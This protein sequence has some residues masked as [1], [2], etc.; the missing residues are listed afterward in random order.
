MSIC[1]VVGGNGGWKPLSLLSD[2]INNKMVVGYRTTNYAL[3][4]I[5]YPAKSAKT[6]DTPSTIRNMLGVYDL[7]A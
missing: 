1:W 4:E 7:A 2:F 5:P 6:Q 3:A